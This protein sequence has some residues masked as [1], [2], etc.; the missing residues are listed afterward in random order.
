[1][2]D[3]VNLHRDP[4]DSSDTLLN[5]GIA[6]HQLLLI[7]EEP[8]FH[9]HVERILAEHLDE[10]FSLRVARDD[11][12]AH[13]A[14]QSGKVYDAVLLDLGLSRCNG[15]E[16]MDT[17]LKT[18]PNLAVIVISE[19][20]EEQTVVEALQRGAMSYLGKT[21]LENS[22]PRTLCKVIEANR[23]SRRI[24]R[25]RDGLAAM[26]MDYE[27]DNDPVLIRPLLD[28][29]RETLDRFGI[30]GGNTAQLI[31]G[32]EEAICNALYH[33]NLEIGS[34]L[35]HTNFSEFYKQADEARKDPRLARRSVRLSIDGSRDGAKITIAD[36][37]QGFDPLAVPDPTLPENLARAHGRGLLMMRTFFD[38]VRFN[39]LGNVVTLTVKIRTEHIGACQDKTEA[40]A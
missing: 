16:L 27:L 12:Q 18:C 2:P 3:P 31:V 29:V 21:T 7:N 11:A 32:I 35:K 30:G 15:F 26:R 1:M 8:A 5:W 37:G 17:M 14:L 33:G 4:F 34:E 38:D 36:D 25:V 13:A 22:L 20:G 40:A 39:K 9:A 6:V 19:I 28:E 10:D 24:S 23:Q